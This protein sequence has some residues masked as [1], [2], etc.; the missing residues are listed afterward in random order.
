METM[1]MLLDVSKTKAE[2][3]NARAD[4][5][6]ESDGGNHMMAGTDDDAQDNVKEQKK[7]YQRV[8]PTASP[9]QLARSPSVSGKRNF[10]FE[11]FDQMFVP[12]E[13]FRFSSAEQEYTPEE[14]NTHNDHNDHR[15]HQ[16]LPPVVT[17]KHQHRAAASSDIALEDGNGYGDDDHLESAANNKVKKKKARPQGNFNPEDLGI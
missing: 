7:P 13:S 12:R 1:M 9:T 5:G 15:H 10:T 3:E 16:P 6:T 4:G 2:Q 11:D 17:T 14:S 8:Q